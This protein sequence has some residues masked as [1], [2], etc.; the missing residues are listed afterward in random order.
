MLASVPLYIS[1]ETPPAL[2]ILKPSE[3]CINAQPEHYRDRENTALKYIWKLLWGLA[4]P[5]G[6]IIYFS[7][8]DSIKAQY[9][10]SFTT[11]VS[12]APFVGSGIAKAI[13]FSA[14]NGLLL[15]VLIAALTSGYIV[16]TVK[17]DVRMRKGTLVF[18]NLK[19]VIDEYGLRS[20]RLV[21]RN[22]G[23]HSDKNMVMVE[24][25]KDESTNLYL[26]QA[27]LPTALRTLGQTLRNDSSKRFELSPNQCKDLPIFEPGGHLLSLI[28]GNGNI[29]IG[30][31]RRY[32]MRLTFSNDVT[33]TTMH[34]RFKLTKDKW[35]QTEFEGDNVPAKREK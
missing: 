14:E 6:A 2:R 34:M 20:Y 10:Q 8:V 23:E 25:L 27:Q 35:L 21:V 15:A 26:A 4:V 32:V 3:S 7:V 29:A 17:N 11:W 1:I 18:E 31:E 22:T 16:A 28:V 9:V 13:S 24:S 19:E 5:L 30:L 12:N 33:S